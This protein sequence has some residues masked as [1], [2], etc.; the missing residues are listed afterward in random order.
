[1]TGLAE[2]HELADIEGFAVMTD[3]RDP[4]LGITTMP[5]NPVN[6]AGDRGGICVS[7]QFTGIIVNGR[8]GDVILDPHCS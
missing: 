3:L 5:I 7:P 1:M 6:N 8:S 4:L 2:N